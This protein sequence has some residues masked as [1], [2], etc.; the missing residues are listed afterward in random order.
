[1]EWKTILRKRLFRNMLLI[2]FAVQLLCC[3]YW[4]W[5][6]TSKK[7]TDYVERYH[8]NIENALSQSDSMNQISIFAVEDGY[9]K[10]NIEKTKQDY[11]G[12]L[13][14]A[15][16]SFDYRGFSAFFEYGQVQ[17][18]GVFF[19]MLLV[20]ALT[21]R[22]AIGL[23]HM[24]YAARDGRGRMIFRKLLALMLWC[25]VLTI[26]LY[27]S[28]FIVSSIRY[29]TNL[30]SALAYPVQSVPAFM[31]VTYDVNIGVFLILFLLCRWLF[32]LVIA[33][34]AWCVYFFI[35]NVILATGVLGGIALVE[36]LFYSVINANSPVC[37]LKYCNLWYQIKDNS[38]FTEYLNL[39]L[40]SYPVSREKISMAVV[41][42]ICV[43]LSVS[44]I[45]KA[46]IVYPAASGHSRVQSFSLPL[47]LQAHLNSVGFEVYKLLVSQRGILLLLVMIF[48][49]IRQ[50][51]Y[52]DTITTGYQ[53]MYEDFIERHEGIPT[54]SAE[55][56]LEELGSFL[57][58][59]KQEYEQ[60]TSD[61]EAGKISSDAYSLVQSKCAAYETEQIFYNE[62][63]LQKQHLESLKADKG[64]EGWYVNLYCYNILFNNGLNWQNLVFVMGMLLLVFGLFWEEKMSGMDVLIRLCK[65]G[66]QEL[67]RKKGILVAVITVVMFIIESVLD[68]TCVY[69]LYGISGFL[70]PVQSIPR[71]AAIPVSCNI[72]QFMVLYLLIKLVVVVVILMLA[73]LIMKKI[74]NKKFVM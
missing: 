3:I 63:M 12:L 40:F 32:F 46:M 28:T 58:E 7:E 10:K 25:A 2:G 45:V 48:V 16:V 39:N 61:Y 1:M 26:A 19:V 6:N 27:G 35:D 18:F 22:N 29:G 21:D 57:E 13:D 49:F 65:Y 24:T 54:E 56:E 31:N 11:E 50:A 53:E 33:V 47:L 72:I 38:F 51:D 9:S 73:F 8:Q 68:I 55:Q 37:I 67:D 17:F 52:T 42:V 41:V 74:R 34:I 60:A 71:L 36:I 30:F 69:N 62:I 44:A 70:A 5:T 43:A 23:R 20:Y 14:I 4:F 64:I 66:R 15:P 59:L